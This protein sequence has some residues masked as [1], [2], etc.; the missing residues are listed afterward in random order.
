MVDIMT[1][2]MRA[3]TPALCRSVATPRPTLRA[4]PLLLAAALA[5]LAGCG[6]KGDL[7]LPPPPR[8]AAPPA[9]PAP[10]ATPAPPAAP[11]TPA[12]APAPAAAR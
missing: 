3:M 4:T 11:T 2:K 8:A 10:A 1:D 9:A 7:Y 5:L 6:Q 12:A